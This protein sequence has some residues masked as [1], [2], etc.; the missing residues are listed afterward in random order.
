L[1]AL[2]AGASEYF[3]KIGADT[4]Q[5]VCLEYAQKRGTARRVKLRWR[6]SRGARRSL[7]SVPLKAARL[8][9]KGRALRFCGKTF[10]VFETE[11]LEGAIA[12]CVCVE[13]DITVRARQDSHASGGGMSTGW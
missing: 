2:T 1:C 9:R 12:S 4:I 3:K 5:R 10:R 6:V 13:P 11:R 8:K 7:G